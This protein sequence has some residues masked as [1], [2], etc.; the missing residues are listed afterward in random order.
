MVAGLRPYAFAL[1]M[2]SLVYVTGFNGPFKRFTG[3]E[4]MNTQKR[5]L[6][7]PR[8]ATFVFSHAYTEQ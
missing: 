7:L 8:E 5:V 1:P 3:I 4:G 2:L 6:A